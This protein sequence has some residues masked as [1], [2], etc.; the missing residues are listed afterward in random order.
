M[1]NQAITK[2]S[3]LLGRQQLANVL[4]D[5]QRVVTPSEAQAVGQPLDVSVDEH[6]WLAER[7]A[8]HDACR[9]TAYSLQSCEVIHRFGHLTAEPFRDVLRARANRLRLLAVEP[10][11]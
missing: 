3:P 5:L 6:G 8:K 4:L 10:G 11:L 7:G 9:F 1:V 2:R